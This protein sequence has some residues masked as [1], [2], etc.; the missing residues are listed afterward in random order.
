MII[1]FRK[2]I[3]TRLF[4]TNCILFGC[5]RLQPLVINRTFTQCVNENKFSNK[6]MSPQIPLI[7]KKY[8]STQNKKQEI[9]MVDKKYLSTQNNKHDNK[10]VDYYID[11]YIYYVNRNK[12]IGYPL[13][14]LLAPIG[15]FAFAFICHIIASV[16]IILFGMIN[17]FFFSRTKNRKRSAIK[18]DHKKDVMKKEYKKIVLNDVKN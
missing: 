13:T 17:D 16:I 15:M 7:D 2:S 4:T 12:L 8:F 5:T 3:P 1:M 14:I 18:R 11:K 6:L 9:I 10:N